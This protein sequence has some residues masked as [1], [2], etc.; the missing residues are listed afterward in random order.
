MECP[1]QLGLVRRMRSLSRRANAA[2]LADGRL[3]ALLRRADPPFGPALHLERLRGLFGMLLRAARASAHRRVPGRRRRRAL[4]RRGRHGHGLGRHGTHRWRIR[5][6]NVWR[7]IEPRLAP[8]DRLNVTATLCSLTRT[9]RDGFPPSCCSTIA[10]IAAATG[11]NPTTACAAATAI[12]ATTLPAPANLAPTN[13]APTNPAPTNPAP[14]TTAASATA[15][16]ATACA[17][18]AGATATAARHMRR[19]P[20]PLRGLGRVQLR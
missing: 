7:R 12:A 2:P 9:T 10:A 8:I 1:L 6:S 20:L 15:N 17:T 16:P 14:V 18:A 13:P 11:A 4:G 3:Q 19:L 5:R